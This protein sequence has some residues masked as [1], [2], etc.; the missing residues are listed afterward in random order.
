M[1]VDRIGLENQVFCS[2]SPGV[3][4]MGAFVMTASAAWATPRRTVPRAQGSDQRPR[5]G[6][7]ARSPVSCR[8]RARYST[9]TLFARLRGWSTSV[10][11]STATW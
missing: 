1:G 8:V 10:P 7:T 6:G 3:V 9:V 2:Q 4:R 5:F 11:F